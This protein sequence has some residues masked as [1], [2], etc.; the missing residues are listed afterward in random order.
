MSDLDIFGDLLEEKFYWVHLLEEMHV[1]IRAFC[2]ATKTYPNNVYNWSN[3][4]TTPNVIKAI[5]F[6]ETYNEFTGQNLTI[7]Q[8]WEKR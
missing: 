6:A 5:E 7:Q 8:M 1:T 4:K 3:S 2:L